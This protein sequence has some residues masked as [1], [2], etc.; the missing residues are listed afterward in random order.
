M[1]LLKKVGGDSKLE[2]MLVIFVYFVAHGTESAEPCAVSESDNSCG[3]S[4]PG[5]S[6]VTR[7]T[8]RCRTAAGYAA[9]DTGGSAGSSSTTA[10]TES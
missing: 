3:G 7:R 8:A 9:T 5:S 4:V 2:L 1:V 6:R 10:D